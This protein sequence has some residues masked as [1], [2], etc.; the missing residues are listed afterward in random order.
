M[1]DTK[2]IPKLILGNK[3]YSSWSLRG[4]LLVRLAGLDCEEVVIPLRRADTRARILEYSPAGKVPTL[5]VEGEAIWDSLSIAEYLAERFPGK[6]LWPN[7]PAARRLARCVTAEMHS[8]FTALRSALPMD[9]SRH[10]PGHPVAAAVQT[11]IDRIQ[12]I[13]RDCRQ[14]FGS[15]G[16]FLFGAAGIADAFYAP[17]VVRFKTYDVKLDSVAAA[18]CDVI[19]DWPPMQD[20]ARDAA[21]ETEI[22][23]FD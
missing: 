8:G 1:T 3:T 17:V 10:S 18:Y 9:L 12:K 7:D 19:S 15:D 20:W 11:D 4:G 5:I 21:G 2:Q 16:G 22:I 14:R 23:V 13:W 6:N